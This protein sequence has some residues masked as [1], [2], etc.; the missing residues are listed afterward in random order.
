MTFNLPACD[1]VKIR[2]D[3]SMKGNEM[4]VRDVV[5]SSSCHGGTISGLGGLLVVLAGLT[6]MSS[7]AMGQTQTQQQDQLQ[8]QTQ[9]QL[10][11]Q[12]MNQNRNMMQN[13][14]RTKTQE[15]LKQQERKRKQEELR[16]R[17]QEELRHRKS[18]GG[19]GMG[20]GGGGSH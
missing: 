18:L 4:K 12:N 11:N 16:H 10:Q 2:K 9:D 8:T 3:H 19:S 13:Q 6:V 1:Q 7:P 14:N 15:E 17:K 5:S 20:G